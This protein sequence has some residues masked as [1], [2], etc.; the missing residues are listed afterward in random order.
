MKNG[1]P[2]QYQMDFLLAEAFAFQ[3]FRQND[4]NFKILV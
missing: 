1:P 3:N 2:I 4:R